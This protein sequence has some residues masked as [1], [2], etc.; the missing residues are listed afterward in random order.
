MTLVTIGSL[1]KTDGDDCHA[2]APTL[3]LFDGIIVQENR[4]CS[5]NGAQ[6]DESIPCE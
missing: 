4:G 1:K 5:P 2:G 6:L 3:V